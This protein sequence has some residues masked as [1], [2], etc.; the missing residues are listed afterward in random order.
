[1]VPFNTYKEEGREGETVGRVI[2]FC[3]LCLQSVA[4][5]DV[6]CALLSSFSA[7]LTPSILSP[8]ICFS[9][10][11]SGRYHHHLII[12]AAPSLSRV[13]KGLRA[14]SSWANERVS[15][16]VGRATD[17]ITRCWP[18]RLFWTGIQRLSRY[19][20]SHLF[21]PAVSCLLFLF[22]FLF[23]CFV[24]VLVLVL[25]SHRSNLL[26]LGS[27]HLTLHYTTCHL[28]VNICSNIIVARVI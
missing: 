17:P 16:L 14:S 9:L 2:G 10:I 15:Q 6:I 25:L 26:A 7:L 28:H 21:A 24:P 5:L 18:M 1:M 12:I 4:C 11:S 8:S 13:R 3:L 22:L 19:P 20:P 23:S 27:F